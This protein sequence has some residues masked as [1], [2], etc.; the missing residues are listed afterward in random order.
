MFEEAEGALY[1]IKTSIAFT[2][3]N[4]EDARYIKLYLV[5]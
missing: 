2:F 1:K 5:Y 3:A 4:A